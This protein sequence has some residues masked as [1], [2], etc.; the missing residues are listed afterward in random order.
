MNDN[1]KTRLK[2]MLDIAVQ[3]E[4]VEEYK[5][6]LRLNEQLLDWMIKTH[7]EMGATLTPSATLR[8]VKKEMTDAESN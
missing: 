7:K 1:Y 6:I 3:E 8:M 2:A 5:A 4:R